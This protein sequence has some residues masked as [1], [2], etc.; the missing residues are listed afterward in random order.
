MSVS[1]LG[2][3]AGN[4]PKSTCIYVRYTPVLWYISCYVS[5]AA[6]TNVRLQGVM[7]GIIGVLFSGYTC[8]QFVFV[9]L[10]NSFA[11]CA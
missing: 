1:M 10:S 5:S 6:Y 7:S 9:L 4:A 2:I 3:A 8:E 11:D